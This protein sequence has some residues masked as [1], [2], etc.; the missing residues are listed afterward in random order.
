MIHAIKGDITKVTNVQ[1]IVNAANES[2]LGGGGV[3]GAIHYAAGPGLLEE[4]KSL[5]GCKM[6]EAKITKGYKLPCD[7]IIHTVGPRWHGGNRG[8]EEILA[9]CYLNSLNLAIEKGIKKVAFPSI[10]TGAFGYPV[11]AAAKVAIDTVNQFLINN[12][13]KIEDVYWVLFDN[14][15]YSVYSN[16]IKRIC[17]A[18]ELYID[19]MLENPDVVKAYLEAMDLGNLGVIA[20][21]KKKYYNRYNMQWLTDKVDSGEKLTFVTFWQA[22]P[23]CENREFSQ[24]YQGEPFVING[25][26]YYTAEQYM[27]SEKALFAKDYD[28]YDKIMQEKDPSECKALGR[29][30]KNLD[31]KGWGKAAREVIFHGN[32]GKFQADISLV[33]KLLS[34]GDAILV[35]ASPRDNLYGS[36][37]AKED[38]LNPDGTLKVHPKDW[39][40]EENPSKQSEN[41]LGFVLMGIRDLFRDLMPNKEV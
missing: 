24:W 31:G 41:K 6:G 17:D 23:G 11:E 22:N 7:Y 21:H 38:L 25:R 34:T 26:E 16:E 39:H 18:G 15:T 37:I 4:C 10:S 27:M 30:V 29:K 3:D 14:Q 8:E 19:K 13:D 1:A 2:L 35:E 12:S 32:L 20:P 5:N 33:D 36:G 28:S 9:S 40:T